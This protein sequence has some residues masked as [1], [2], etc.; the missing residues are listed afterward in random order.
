MPYAISWLVDKR[1]LYTR[2]YGFVTG[3][4]LDIQKKEMEL[5][6]QQSE[7]LLHMITDATDMTG[8]NMGLRDLQ[9]MQFASAANLGWAIYVS[10]N[11]MNRFFA[12]VVTQL[13]KK[14]GREYATLEE[15]LR[16]LQDMDDTLPSLSL[17]EKLL[18][19]E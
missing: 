11:K 13:M 19:A 17:P 4:D 1:V 15:G 9:K 3:A 8:T 12:S 5:Y 6:I 10:P 14:R 7:Q 2:M 16:F 18:V